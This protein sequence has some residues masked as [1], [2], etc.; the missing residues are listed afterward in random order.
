MGR[1]GR[2]G[3]RESLELTGVLA[4]SDPQGRLRLCLVDRLDSRG[5]A[6]DATWRR[7]CAAIPGQEG[8]TAPYRLDRS[9]ASDSAGIRGECWIA[10]PPARRQR[11]LAYARELAGREVRLVARPK[12]F[13]FVSRAARNR[14]Q[15]VEGT[16]LVLVGELLPLVREPELPGPAAGGGV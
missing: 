9:G 4:T 13:S 11:L 8:R 10:L 12:G 14:G 16:S 2:A 5:G 15:L 3:Q 1:Q 6:Y 7:L